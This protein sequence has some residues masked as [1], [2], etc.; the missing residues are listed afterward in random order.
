MDSSPLAK[1]SAE[2]RNEIYELALSFEDTITVTG[3]SASSDLECSIG[4]PTALIQTCRQIRSEATRMFY[5]NNTFHIGGSGSSDSVEV[6]D[7]FSVLQRF[8]H[9]IGLHN[10]KAI[11]R[12]SVE[13]VYHQRMHFPLEPSA[14]ENI[15]AQIKSMRHAAQFLDTKSF[16]CVLKLYSLFQ[17]RFRPAVVV[18]LDVVDYEDSRQKAI[19][20]N[21]EDS[22]DLGDAI[23]ARLFLGMLH[24]DFGEEHGE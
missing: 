3:T 6:T 16:K 12:I 13:V 7:A 14:M 22:L 2:L 19:A 23:F 20:K 9:T 17:H 8:S 4:H 1:L 10:S 24:K 11:K 18:E 21:R 5:A 15:N